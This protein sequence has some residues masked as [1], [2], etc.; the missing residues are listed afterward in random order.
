M[1]IVE[2]LKI[3]V[4]SAIAKQHI[5]KDDYFR[6]KV[7]PFTKILKNEFAFIGLIVNLF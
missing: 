6:C 7:T 2:S 5:T 1:T 3:W 4:F